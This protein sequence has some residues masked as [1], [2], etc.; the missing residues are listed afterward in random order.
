MIRVKL[1]D[2]PAELLDKGTTELAKARAHFGDQANQG[3]PFAFA[4]YKL[5]SVKGA[6]NDTFHFKCAYCES[7]FEA[8]QPLDVEHFRPKS[9]VLVGDDL[10]WGVYFWLAAKW[11][12]LLPSCTD[13]NRPRKQ[14][15]PDGNE[16]TLGK[17]N[18]FP[19]ASEAK[20]AAKEGEEKQEGRLLVHPSLDDPSKHFVFEPDGI[21]SWKSSKGR[22][23]I[24]VYALLRRGLVNRRKELQLEIRTHIS[25]ARGLARKLEDDGPDADLEALLT[26][27]LAALARFIEPAHVYSAMARALI[28]PVLEE[29]MG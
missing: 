3:E 6:L 23:S 4:A 24:R 13:C 26:E 15:L 1:P 7:S 12:N 19:I 11:G 9:G 5:G 14:N 2:A 29:L 21:V 18:Q 25:I 22:E 17:A 28:D 27:E 10:V 16:Q 8:T 20:R